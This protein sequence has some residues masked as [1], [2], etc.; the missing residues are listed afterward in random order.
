MSKI[1]EPSE[2][3]DADLARRIL[4]SA[5][6]AARAEEA[7]LCRRFAPRVR[8]FGMRRLNDEHAAADL[9]QRVLLLTVEKLRGREVREPERIASFVLGAAR[10][11][12]IETRRSASRFETGAPMELHL[13]AVDTPEPIDRDRL[14]RCLEALSERERAVP[15]AT[16]FQA[17][18]APAIARSLPLKAAAVRVIRHRALRRLRDCVEPAAAGA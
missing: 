8:L 15:V 7:E 4:E 6:G 10:M 1:P 13:P 18:D 3:R 5:P 2:L 11:L 17:D 14:A 12:V 16:F 9:V